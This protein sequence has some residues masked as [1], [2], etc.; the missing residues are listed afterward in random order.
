MLRMFLTASLVITPCLLLRSVRASD[1][2]AEKQTAPAPAAK[3]IPVAKL[4]RTSPVDFEKEIL[5]VL[6]TSC[7]ACHSKTKP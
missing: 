6:Q 2:A 5:P 3:P 4:D 1:D 7:L